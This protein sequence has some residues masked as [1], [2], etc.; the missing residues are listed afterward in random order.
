MTALDLDRA[1]ARFINASPFRQ[2]VFKKNG[3]LYFE[4][5]R[6]TVKAEVMKA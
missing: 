1:T 4:A 6:H 5:V 2:E 3:W